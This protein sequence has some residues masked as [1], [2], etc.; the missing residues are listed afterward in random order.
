MTVSQLIEILEKYDPS[1]EVL[2]QT[3]TFAVASQLTAPRIKNQALIKTGDTTYVN[4]QEAYK[5]NV[6]ITGSIKQVIVIEAVLEG[7]SQK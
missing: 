2:T 3:D 4:M 7:I 5:H 6:A 1:V